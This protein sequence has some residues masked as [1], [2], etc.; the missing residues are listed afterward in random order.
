[1]AGGH[2]SRGEVDEA[3]LLIVGG[4]NWIDAGSGVSG[5]VAG[6]FKLECFAVGGREQQR[7][8]KKLVFV[9]VKVE[10]NQW[11]ILSIVVRLEEELKLRA[12]FKYEKIKLKKIAF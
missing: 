5:D 2:R 6:R 1:M 7:R 10:R 12:F 3:V 9:V 11:R 4:R 8:R